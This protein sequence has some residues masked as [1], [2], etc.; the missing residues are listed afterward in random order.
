VPSEKETP[1]PPVKAPP[2]PARSTSRT[3]PPID[4]KR[5]IQAKQRLEQTKAELQAASQEKASAEQALVSA[6]AR[7][8]AVTENLKP[9]PQRLQ[10]ES[11]ALLREKDLNRRLE[12]VDEIRSSRTDWSSEERAWLDQQ[13]ELLDAQ[14]DVEAAGFGKKKQA[15]NVRDATILEPVRRQELARASKSVADLIRSEGPNYREVGRMRNYDEVMG[16]QAWNGL[17]AAR[18]SGTAPLALNTDHIVSVREI[19]DQVVSSGLLE[20]H[21]KA[22]PAVKEQ[23]EKAIQGLG[24]ERANLVRMERFANQTWK[25]DRSWADISYDKVASLYTREMVDSMRAREATLR[26][27]Y[28]Q[29]IRDLVTQLSK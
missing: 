18:A 2:A 6:Q 1:P 15:E 24:D 5:Q 23:I 8:K 14:L 25:S 17:K 21:D 12:L 10:S 27:H 9:V 29:V 20:L 13:A 3:N 28:A 19:R 7:V 11:K 4:T 22:S 16:E 26:E